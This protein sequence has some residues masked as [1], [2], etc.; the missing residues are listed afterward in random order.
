MRVP[1]LSATEAVVVDLMTDRLL[2][3]PPVEDDAAD[4]LAMLSDSEAAAARGHRRSLVPG[5]VP[6]AVLNTAMGIAV[7]V[8]ERR[9]RK[10]LRAGA[11]A[12]VTASNARDSLT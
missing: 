6:R 7:I 2:V 10:A 1:P 4:A 11:E 3:R 8:L 12:A 5:F 9:I